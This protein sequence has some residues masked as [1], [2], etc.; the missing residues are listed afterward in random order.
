M[1]DISLAVAFGAGVLSFLSPC[2]LP[3]IPGY[4]SF[5]SGAGA[6]EL[7]A[8]TRRAGVLYRTLFFV[9]GFSTVFVALGLVFSGA[10]ML[11][12][13][14]SN[15]YLSIAAGS[16]LVVLGLNTMFDF[17]RFLNAE[18]RARVSS[19]PTSAA[20]ALLVGMAFG[21][22]WTPCVGPILASILFMAA[23]SGG[24]GKA[25]LLLSLYSAG[26]ALPFIAAGLFFAQLAPLWA[27]FKRHGR[28]VKTVSG[29]LLVVIGLSM[30]LGR[31]TAFNAAASRLG[32][33]VKSVVVSN[34]ATAKAWT[35]G[36]LAALAAAATLPPVILGH[37]FAT[38]A[39]L[40]SLGVLS[41]LA[42]LEL[43]GIVSIAGVL[44]GWLLF[45]GV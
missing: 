37:R 1:I 38:P 33:L 32:F 4:L 10:G 7:R 11:A 22:G 14:R 8:G 27:W 20:G 21:A 2:I 26:L 6:D 30:A 28:A 16:V 39:R 41:V 34:P 35:L 43:S 19:R 25:A 12:A 15:R 5:L 42:V 31:M 29:A 36:L 18:V 9:L 17:L 40:V 23:R 3:L 44:S 13:G 24:A 45:Q